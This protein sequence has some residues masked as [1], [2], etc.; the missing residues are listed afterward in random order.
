MSPAAAARGSQGAAPLFA[1][2]GDST[3]LQLVARL[4]RG[5]PQSVSALAEDATISRQA[6][7]KHLQVLEEAGLAASWR[8]GRERLFALR[9]ERLVAVQRYLDQIGRHWDE[10]LARLQAHV[11]QEK[12]RK[13]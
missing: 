1:A 11:E 10:A 3:R 4:S 9:P 5:G 6:V 8:E 13:P 7:T 12:G 2:L